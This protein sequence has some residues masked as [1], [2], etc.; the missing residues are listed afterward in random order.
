MKL[1]RE[2][3]F[4]PALCTCTKIRTDYSG[5]RIGCGE[6]FGERTG[7]PGKDLACKPARCQPG[8]EAQEMEEILSAAP[9]ELLAEMDGLMESLDEAEE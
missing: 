6:A 4:V 7:R 2:E 3:G 5:G 8:R 9:A 1:A